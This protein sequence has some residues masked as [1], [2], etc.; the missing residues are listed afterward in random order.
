MTEYDK[1]IAHLKAK[2]SKLLPLTNTQVRFI[3]WLLEEENRKQAEQVGD[4]PTLFHEIWKYVK[5]L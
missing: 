1:F 3:K 2:E 4:L 5:G